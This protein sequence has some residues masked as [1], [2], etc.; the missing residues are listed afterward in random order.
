MKKNDPIYLP[1]E[2]PAPYGDGQEA[3]EN[4][5]QKTMDAIERLD[6]MINTPKQ[7]RVSS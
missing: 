6:R 7:K 5:Q 2:P 3:Y 4:H 1:D